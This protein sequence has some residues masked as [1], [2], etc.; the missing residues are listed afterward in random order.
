[1]YLHRGQQ[2]VV[3]RLDLEKHNIFV[4]GSRARYYTQ[5]KSEKE[6]TILERTRSRPLGNILLRL[7]EVEVEETV[8]GFEKRRIRSGEKMSLHP[9]DLPPQFF[10]TEGLWFEIDNHILNYLKKNGHTKMGSMHALEHAAIALFPLFVYC[11]RFDIGGICYPAH[12]Q[13]GKGGIFIYDGYPG[14][15]GL[16]AKCFNVME[17][18]LEAVVHLLEECTCENGC[19]SCIHSPKCGAGNKPLDKAGCLLLT[20]IMLGQI[21]PQVTAVEES[22]EAAYEEESPLISEE[23]SEH[24]VLVFD[25]ETQRSAEDVGGWRNCHLMRLA[26]GCV[27]DSKTGQ[28]RDYYER[29]AEELVDALAGADLVVGFNVKRFDYRVLSGY[30]GRNMAS[31]STFDMLEAVNNVI[32]Y[33]LS[34]GHLGETTLQRPKTADGLQSLQWWKEGK[35]DLVT[36]YCRADVELT[37]DLF[38]HGIKEGFLL[39]ERKNAG[40]VR[41]PVKW[42]LEKIVE[43]AQ[44]K[45]MKQATPTRMRRRRRR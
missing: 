38:Y 27:W 14:G 45:R 35:H 40:T 2:F 31:I 19:P 26:V 7:G 24:Q 33:R 18:L 22:I 17:E 32:G 15:V 23:E 30:S 34:L 9:L 5:V 20:K 44:K 37:R 1:M 39:Y 36:Q 43:E 13:L 16:A 12:P 10:E 8:V 21:D 25:L 41:L 4:A 29:E 42:D 6:T 3:K 28:M 11:D